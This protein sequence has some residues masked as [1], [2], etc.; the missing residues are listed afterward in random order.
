MNVFFFSLCG[1]FRFGHGIGGSE[2]LYSCGQAVSEDYNR[3][4]P[5]LQPYFENVKK[6]SQNYFSPSSTASEGRG[7]GQG[8]VVSVAE[9][10]VR[11]CVCVCVCIR[12]ESRGRVE[13]RLLWCTVSLQKLQ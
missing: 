4:L 7:W 2:R 1:E 11:L 8:I 3:F 6:N 9:A 10:R 13:V 12:A 5:P